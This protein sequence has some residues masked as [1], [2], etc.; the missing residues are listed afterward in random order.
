MFVATLVVD[1]PSVPFHRLILS[2]CT[3][4]SIISNTLE[5]SV[6]EFTSQNYSSFL[7]QNLYVSTWPT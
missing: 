7:P 6:A 2:K 3:I 1:L 4:F 5:F